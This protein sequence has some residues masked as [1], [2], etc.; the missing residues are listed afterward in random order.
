MKSFLSKIV[1]GFVIAGLLS[2]SPKDKKSED[3]EDRNAQFFDVVYIAQA[4]RLIGTSNWVTV[5]GDFRMK[6]SRSAGQDESDSSGGDYTTHFTSYREAQLYNNGLCSGGFLG[7]FALRE[8]VDD[9]EG[10]VDGPYN[11]MNPYN[12]GTT[13]PEEE[14][15]TSRFVFIFTLTVTERSLAASCAPLN[16]SDPLSLRVIRF[17]NG[18]LIVTNAQRNL[19]FYMIPELIP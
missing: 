16:P 9:V 3:F 4:S 17:N 18:D 13:N 19:E 15:D 7:T 6:F 1:L 14:T 10:G 11:P 12:S 8:T 5:E 2:C